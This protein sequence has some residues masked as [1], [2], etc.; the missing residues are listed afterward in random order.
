MLIARAGTL[1]NKVPFMR[2]AGIRLTMTLTRKER[3]NTEGSIVVEVRI[4]WKMIDGNTVPGTTVGRPGIGLGIRIG[5]EIKMWI[6]TCT[7]KRSGRKLA[8][9]RRLIGCVEGKK[10]VEGIMRGIETM[11]KKIG[12]GKVTRVGIG[13]EKRKEIGA[14]TQFMRG[15]GEGN[16]KEL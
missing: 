6:E 12:A 14:G 9:I 3:G 5:V 13:E 15:I 10:N 7:G 8:G 16:W 2:P 1:G 11:W 4:C